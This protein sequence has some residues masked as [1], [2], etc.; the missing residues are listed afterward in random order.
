MV[1]PTFR[2]A[3]PADAYEMA[4]MSRYLVEVGLRGWSSEAWHQRPYVFRRLK[5]S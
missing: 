3:N 4:V 2:L 1:Q 5:P